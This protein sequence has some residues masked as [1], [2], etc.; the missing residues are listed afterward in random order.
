M[1]LVIAAVESCVIPFIW[2]KLPPG[3]KCREASHSLSLESVLLRAVICLVSWT[4]YRGAEPKCLFYLYVFCI[5]SNNLQKAKDWKLITRKL[6]K[7]TYTYFVHRTESLSILQLSN[8]NMCPTNY[9]TVP[10]WASSIDHNWRRRR[11]RKRI[12]F[13]RNKVRVPPPSC[14]KLSRN[15]NVNWNLYVCVNV[16]PSKRI[17]QPCVTCFLAAIE[18]EKRTA[19]FSEVEVFQKSTL[20]HTETAEKNPL[21]TPQGE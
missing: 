14:I 5:Y 20:H 15:V 10:S 19:P 21:P 8:R 2:A 17:K 18:D 11:Q 4:S 9:R 13:Q 7:V 1:G 16:A 6:N 3:F 12:P